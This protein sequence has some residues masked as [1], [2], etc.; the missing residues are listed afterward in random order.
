MKS[1]QMRPVC[2]LSLLLI[3]FWGTG[4]LAGNLP[5]PQIELSASD[6]ESMLEIRHPQLSGTV[7]IGNYALMTSSDTQVW[8]AS[9]GE[10]VSIEVTSGALDFVHSRHLMEPGVSQFFR[11][12]L[13]YQK[14]K[15]NGVGIQSWVS[16]KPTNITA[17]DCPH[18]IGVP[19]IFKWANLEPAVDDY[20]FESEIGSLLRDA[21]EQGFYVMLMTWVALDGNTPDWLFDLGVP[22]VLTDAVVDPLGNPVSR[23]FPYYFDPLYRER[24]FK[25]HERLGAYLRTLP[26]PLRERIVFIQS[27]EGSTGDG[28]PYKGDPLNR[29]Y[30]IGEG[31]WADFRSEVWQFMQDHYPD[32]P[33]LVNGD[34][35]DA[36]QTDWLVENLN[37]IAL[38]H[39]MFSHGFHVS[40][41][42]GRLEDFRKIMT[43]AHA[44]GKEV[45]TRGEM[46]AE[47]TTYGWS[48]RNIPQSLYW[49]GLMATHTLLDVWNIPYEQCKIEANWPALEFFNR[50]AGYHHAN[51]SPR[52]FC[53]LRDGLNAADFERFPASRFGGNPGNKRDIQRYLAIAAAYASYGA[54]QEDPDKATGGGMVNRKRQGRNDVGWNIFPGNYDRFLKQLDPGSGDVG[55]WNVDERIYGRFARGFEHESGK[56]RMLFQLDPQFFIQPSEPQAVG[57]R[58]VWLD[59]GTGTWSLSYRTAEGG[60]QQLDVQNTDS[61]E[62]L[63]RDFELSDVVFTQS[64]EGGDLRLRYENGDNTLFHLLEIER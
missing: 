26:E 40:E 58:I 41:N 21:D 46:D 22:K 25:L 20:R 35:N 64:V 38:K 12:E 63:T 61:G 55:H 15:P 39:G 32:V 43:A 42:I 49:S 34:A 59:S 6:P 37:V 52:A 30:R 62:W 18:L 9:E 47:M 8:K 24:F 10:V 11:V 23:Y 2:S 48:T 56:T 7:G 54:V 1:E 53:A 19:M 3:A 16:W 5:S 17:D 51:R 27:A 45:F 31:E 28:G 57:L 13:D 50:Y 14:T 29:I 4:L 60:I 44:A 33:L 36:V